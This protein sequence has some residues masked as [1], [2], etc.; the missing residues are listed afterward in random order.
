MYRTSR[1][2]FSLLHCLGE[3]FNF[4]HLFSSFALYSYKFSTIIL[5]TS[6]AIF[7]ES[8]LYSLII[9]IDV[10][11]YLCTYVIRLRTPNSLTD[12]IITMF[13]SSRHIIPFQH[14]ARAGADPLPASQGLNGSYLCVQGRRD[15]Y[16]NN[17]PLCSRL[18]SNVL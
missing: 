15:E 16:I 1:F 17:I 4:E 5:F 3:F 9:T 12:H 8:T 14:R 10:S 11:I 13:R 6:Y 18:Q 7:L 2:R